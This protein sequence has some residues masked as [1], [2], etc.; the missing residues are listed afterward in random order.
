MDFETWARLS[1]RLTLKTEAQ[2]RA[3]FQE[4]GSEAAEL[5]A[6]A[7]KKHRAAMDRDLAAGRTRRAQ[8]YAELCAAEADKQ[9][10]V[11]VEVERARKPAPL[12]A[13]QRLDAPVRV[14]VAVPTFLLP[15]Q[16]ED[17][18]APVLIHAPAAPASGS[19]GSTVDVSEL[20]LALEDAPNTLPFA[21]SSGATAPA[22]PAPIPLQPNPAAGSTLDVSDL[23]DQLDGPAAPAQAAS[24]G[25]TLQ[26]YASLCVE[27]Q[28]YPGN[29]LAV[30][31]RYTVEPS[32]LESLQQVWQLRL[33]SNP[34][35]AAQWREAC[36]D[37]AAWI[38]TRAR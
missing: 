11:S 38:R 1:A 27:L 14:E 29:K 26:Q 23:G 20:S 24:S 7:G 17:A 4:I 3:I 19:A 10:A 35:L 2:Q 9:R 6:A 21:G 31:R 8:R 5:F 12:P 36:A 13:P 22:L 28:L 34:A 33:R 37:Y 18:P 15:G 16:M 32:Q 25:L 30:L